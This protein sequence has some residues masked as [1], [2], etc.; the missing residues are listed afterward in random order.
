M[1]EQF[2]QTRAARLPHPP[3][4]VRERLELAAMAIAAVPDRWHEIA[5]STRRSLGL[6]DPAP[7]RT[8]PVLFV[9]ENGSS[10]RR[11]LPL[12]R[13]EEIGCGGFNT[14]FRT[15]DLVASVPFV[16]RA[17]HSAR[18]AAEVE[19]FLLHDGIVDD[20]L[21]TLPVHPVIPPCYGRG[22]VDARPCE[23][24]GYAPGTNLRSFVARRGLTFAA[25][26]DIA[27]C[28]ALG[29]AHI[30]AHGLVHSDV[31]PDNF[32]VEERGLRRGHT[33]VRSFLID[34]DVV[35]TPEA[36]VDGYLVGTHFAGT[37]AYMPPENF[38]GAVPARSG[39]RERMACSKDVYALGL[40]LFDLLTGFSLPAVPRPARTTGGSVALGGRRTV[41]LPDSVPGE[42]R[43]LVGAMWASSWRDRPT[44]A[45]AGAVL[46]RLRRTTPMRLLERLLVEPRP[47]VRYRTFE[48]ALAAGPSLGPYLI[49]DPEFRV[50][51]APADGAP[52]TIVEL[53][54]A[55]GRRLLGIPF[56]FSSE[57]DA[58]RFY[59]ERRRL[60]LDLN[61]VRLLHPDLFSGTFND[62]VRTGPGPA[63]PHR[64]WFI[65]P[66]LP[67]ALPLESFLKAEPDVCL[68]ER[69]AILRR[70]A[71]SL[72]ALESAGYRHH[73][74]DGG[75][76]FF[77]PHPAFGRGEAGSATRPVVEGRR[78]FDVRASRPYHQ[79]LMGM[80]DVRR[81]AAG[82]EDETVVQ[83]LR[84]ASILGVLDQGAPG[85][86]AAV[87][88]LEGA[89][90]W[91]RR[92]EIL[93]GIERRLDPE[94]SGARQQAALTV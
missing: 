43:D 1:I 6:Q 32:C 60:L 91:R 26:L 25:L 55:Y 88:A 48:E 76:V 52:G 5:S 83:V 57:E 36:V 87:R 64:V 39:E 12:D 8:A 85:L 35:S 47:R 86:A 78:T 23:L 2:T 90:E 69:V 4:V 7:R 79:E 58:V 54:D 49:V 27:H 15:R 75:T 9:E 70:I 38:A 65:R 62:L 40:T 11:C 20:R 14:V 51:V 10:H 89:G 22:R 16:V 81:F 72:A 59:A 56:G 17:R 53:E 45:E 67:G 74:I 30:H 94:R 19:H 61:R 44:A 82:E 50:R 84:L 93:L 92:A 33:A 68:R 28:A 46:R 24:F 66:L 77:V 31:K 71:Q 42:L 37:P 18:S 41:C 34:F 21:K 3:R 80:A 63:G 73:G 13:L 29:L